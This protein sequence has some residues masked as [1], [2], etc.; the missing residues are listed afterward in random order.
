MPQAGTTRHIFENT[1]NNHTIVQSIKHK[2]KV[3]RYA[4]LTHLVNHGEIFIQSWNIF[5]I[6]PSYCFTSSITNS[7]LTRTSQSKYPK[8]LLLYAQPVFIYR[9]NDFYQYHLL[10]IVQIIKS[11]ISLQPEQL[12]K[13]GL[14]HRILLKNLLQQHAK[15]KALP[16]LF[17]FSIIHPPKVQKSKIENRFQHP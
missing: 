14:H 17:K 1:N 2:T 13:F 4:T 8:Q 9:S 10:R 6:L 12:C 11:L 7:N 16:T 3:K 15:F 5:Y